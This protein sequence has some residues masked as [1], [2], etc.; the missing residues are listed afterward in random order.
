MPAPIMRRGSAWQN[1]ASQLLYARAI[2]AAKRASVV[3]PA[4]CR[5]VG[6]ELLVPLEVAA[7]LK[8]RPELFASGRLDREA[9]A[10]V[11]HVV[12]R[13]ALGSDG[14]EF[15]VDEALPQIGRLH[16]VHIAVEDF[17]SA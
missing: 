3:R 15:G 1:S 10:Q 2:A 11:A 5:V 7:P 8:V 14:L 17:E 13:D 16:D 6:V 9:D 4:P 12:G